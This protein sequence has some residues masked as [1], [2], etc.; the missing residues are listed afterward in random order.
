MSALEQRHPSTLLGDRVKLAAYWVQQRGEYF[1]DR[2]RPSFDAIFAY[3]V[4]GFSLKRPPHVPSEIFL[5]EVCR[6]Y[7]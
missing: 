2:H 6:Q 5:G 4:E 7:E 1:F 3:L